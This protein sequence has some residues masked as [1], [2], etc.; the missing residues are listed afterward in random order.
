MIDKKRV[1]SEH[2]QDINDIEDN[3]DEEMGGSG[4]NN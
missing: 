1:D 4:Q 2:Q 3:D